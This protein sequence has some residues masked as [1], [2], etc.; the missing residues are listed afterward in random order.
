MS[1]RIWWPAFCANESASPA[2]S[3]PVPKMPN[4]VS[5]RNASH[6]P[7]HVDWLVT[8]SGF[9]LARFEALW[10][11]VTRFLT[12]ADA[13][14]IPVSAARSAHGASGAITIPRGT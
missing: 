11:D 1:W 7:P 10:S 8:G 14:E 4:A 13:T 12:R 3:S 5:F 6:D 9:D 2:P